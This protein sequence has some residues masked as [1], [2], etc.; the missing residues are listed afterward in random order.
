MRER[1]FLEVKEEEKKDLV[2]A[3]KNEFKLTKN[4]P[5]ENSNGEIICYT[6]KHDVYSSYIDFTLTDFIND[7]VTKQ[8]GRIQ[9][10][11]TFYEEVIKKDKKVRYLRI[12]SILA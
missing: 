11:N 10:I 9:K 6:N 4:I 12:K 2:E 8:L 1:L 7:N 5:I 3:L